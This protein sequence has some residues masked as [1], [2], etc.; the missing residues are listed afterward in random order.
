MLHTLAAN[1]WALA[2]RGLVAV[3]FG[4]LTFFLP[5]ITLAVLVIL[6]GAYAL[7]DG[8]FNF[9]AFFRR[10]YRRVATAHIESGWVPKGTRVEVIAYFDNSDDNQN[11]PDIPPRA[12]RLSELSSEPL[13][14]LL[15]AI[16]DAASTPPATR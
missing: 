11:N 9:I 6:F 8:I 14:T 16:S 5:G 7:V 3:L 13:C 1:W 4:L 10:D 2:L 12:M 15:V